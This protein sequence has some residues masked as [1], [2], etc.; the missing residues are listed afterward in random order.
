MEKI[1]GFNVINITSMSKMFT[2]CTSFSGSLK[3]WDTSNCLSMVSI[4]TIEQATY[5]LNNRLEVTYFSNL[6]HP[7]VL[8]KK[9]EHPFLF[10]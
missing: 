10:E 3:G 6:S 7:H 1:D 9:S 4:R 2:G 5:C 8:V